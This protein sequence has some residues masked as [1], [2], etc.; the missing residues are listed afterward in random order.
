MKAKKTGKKVPDL[1][2]LRPKKKPFRLEVGKTYTNRSGSM[3]VQII[4]RDPDPDSPYWEFRG[5]SIKGAGKVMGGHSLAWKED[6]V[7]RDPEY[8]WV[9]SR[10]LVREFRSAK[11]TAKPSKKKGKS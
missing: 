2:G 3:V 4:E 10:D 9:K 5:A 6:G 11:R 8:Q 1:P 7:W